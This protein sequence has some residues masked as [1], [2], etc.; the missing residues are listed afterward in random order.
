MDL[1]T[2]QN[3]CKKKETITKIKQE[4]R[5]WEKIGTNLKSDRGLI[6]K[7]LR[8]L[9][10]LGTKN[11]NNPIRRWGIEVNRELQIA[12]Q[13]LKDCAKSLVIREKKIQTTLRFHLPPI[14]MEL[15]RSM[16]QR[17]AHDDNGVEQGNTPYWW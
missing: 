12:K 15:L 10:K 5:D 17:T 2:G 7:M 8:E 14:R 6:F 11:P 13:Y 16:T 3:F 9:K 4:P 1:L